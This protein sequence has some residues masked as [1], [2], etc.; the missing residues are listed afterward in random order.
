MDAVC[1]LFVEQ[2]GQRTGDEASSHF[3]RL[4]KWASCRRGSQQVASFLG[5]AACI[6][7]EKR[8]T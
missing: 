7:A 8:L 1:D 4:H 6:E 2:I 3:L 5:T